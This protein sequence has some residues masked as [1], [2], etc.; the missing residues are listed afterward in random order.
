MTTEH[1]FF[2]HLP[3]RRMWFQGSGLLLS[4]WSVLAAI[5][6][7]SSLGVL[8]LILDLLTYQGRIEATPAELDKLSPWVTPVNRKGIAEDTGIRSTLWRH[9]DCP[10]VTW[11]RTPLS[12]FIPLRTNRGTLAVLVVVLMGKY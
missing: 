8:F 10:V 7:A 4:A 2:R 11:V 1:S 5:S 12:R 3:P 6:L 9:R